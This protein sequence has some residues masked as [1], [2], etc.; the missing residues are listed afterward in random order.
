MYFVPSRHGARAALAPAPEEKRQDDPL[1]SFFSEIFGGGNDQPTTSR[2]RTTPT[3][4]RTTTVGVVVTPTPTP[5]IES[6]PIPLLTST[7]SVHRTSTTTTSR[8]LSTA[9][10]VTSLPPPPIVETS[11]SAITLTSTATNSTNTGATDASQANS[12]SKSG[13]P[14]PI[15]GLI[16][17]ASVIFGLIFLALVARKLFQ[18][19]R[20]NKRATWARTSIIAPFEVPSGVKEK[21]L[22]APPPVAQQNNVE[23]PG[24]PPPAMTY[25]QPIPYSPAAPSAGYSAPYPFG[26]TGN[27]KNGNT[28]TLANPLNPS[29]YTPADLAG[30]PPVV[31]QQPA[32]AL[33]TAIPPSM[34][35]ATTSGA[36]AAAAATSATTT[37]GGISIVK[38][39]FVPSLPDELSISNGD[40]VRVLS[41]YDDGWAMCEKVSTGERGVVPQE[42]L[43]DVKSLSPNTNTPAAQDASDKTK[44]SRASSLKR[45]EGTY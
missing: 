8:P 25:A 9:Q 20:R 32:T 27:A 7:P 41:I 14:S 23:Y 38:L 30:A 44:M 18:A 36:T 40:Q 39:T 31:I 5:V 19:R 26:A 35:L 21:A 15:V 3:V 28:N 43:E 1:A 13:L 29:S 11:T 24:Y 17:A 37:T 10:V 33:S 6:P 4:P 2:P 34:L 42:C 22:P 16:V 45:N 12:S